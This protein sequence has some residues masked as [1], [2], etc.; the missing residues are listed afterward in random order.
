[1]SL[2]DEKAMTKSESRKSKLSLWV[3]AA[4]GPTFNPLDEEAKEMLTPDNSLP[5]LDINVSTTCFLVYFCGFVLV[6]WTSNVLLPSFLFSSGQGATR[7]QGP[8]VRLSGYV[9]FP[10]FC[11]F[12]VEVWLLG[13]LHRILC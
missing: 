11:S 10:C 12:L 2:H 3:D 8:Q 13:A 5:G 7:V 1:M 6:P 4:V 9:D